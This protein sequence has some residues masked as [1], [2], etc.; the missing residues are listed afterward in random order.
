[1]TLQTV[2]AEALKLPLKERAT[3]ASSLLASLEPDD[4]AEIE[5]LWADVAERRAAESEADPS[6]GI[7]VAESDTRILAMLARAA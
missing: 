4:P 7:P 5:A 6:L 3:L 1:M 2:E